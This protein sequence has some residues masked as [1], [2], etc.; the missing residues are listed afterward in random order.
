MLQ[1]SQLLSL[2]NPRAMSML[3]DSSPWFLT[4]TIL[5]EANAIFN[6]D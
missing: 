5:L 3:G 1:I 2:A 4:S 6:T